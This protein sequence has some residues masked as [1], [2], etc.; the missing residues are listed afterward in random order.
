MQKK[1]TVWSV[2]ML[3]LLLLGAACSSVRHVPDGKY[4]LNKVKV[5]IDDS[6]HTLS[7]EEML[8]YVRQQPNH[9]L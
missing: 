1:G 8:L 4:L 7:E 3:L 9:K 5:N 6:T 2:A